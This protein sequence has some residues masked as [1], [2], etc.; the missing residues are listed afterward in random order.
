MN[1][2]AVNERAVVR[3]GPRPVAA[4]SRA[5]TGPMEGVLAKACYEVL[6]DQALLQGSPAE[7]QLSAGTTAPIAAGSLEVQ[8]NLVARQVL[9][10]P[11]G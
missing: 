9:D 5:L 10:L 2:A 6:G 8:L 11:K 7:R 1:Y 3:S 4:V